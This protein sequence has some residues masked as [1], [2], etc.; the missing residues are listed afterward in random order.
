MKK[1]FLSMLALALTVG[2]FAQTQNKDQ[3]QDRKEWKQKGDNNFQD[4]LNLT[5]AQK[6]QM[7]TL[8][9]SFRSKMQNLRQDKSL[10]QEVQKQKREELMKEHRAQMQSML[11]PEQKKQWEAN[12]KDLGSK[13]W[14]GK[15]KHEGAGK[16]EGDDK[17]S[18]RGGKRLGHVQQFEKMSKD[19]NLTDDQSARLK[20]MNETFRTNMQSIHNNNALSSD[21]KKEQMKNLQSKHQEDIKSILTKEQQTKFNTEFKSK[22]NRGS[23]RITK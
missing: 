12:R 14:D 15:G 3:K 17:G 16:H 18:M 22:K 11:T 19:L 1:I 8:N 23:K 13:K 10:S 20:S 21:Q 4:K 2:S 6:A 5:D 9:E 7:K